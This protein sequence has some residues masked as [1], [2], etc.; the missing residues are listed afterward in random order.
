[1]QMLQHV[2]DGLEAARV[3]V[4]A[5]YRSDEATLGTP[6]ARIVERLVRHPATTSLILGRMPATEVLE[7]VARLTGQA[8]ASALARRVADEADGNPFFVEE[9]VKHLAA[10]RPLSNGVPMPES[11][12]LLLGHKLQRLSPAGRDL[13]NLVAVAG[14]DVDVD[15]MAAALGVDEERTVD[16]V[17]NAPMVRPP[18]YRSRGH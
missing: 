12:R 17:D 1:M 16:A 2:A 18:R 14:R 3:L 15:L 10:E 11:L 6:L 5:T 7:L 8:P 4:I 9:L 13:V